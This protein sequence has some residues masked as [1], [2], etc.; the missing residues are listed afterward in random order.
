MKKSTSSHQNAEDTPSNA[1]Q[2]AAPDAIA[3]TGNS[4][5]VVPQ[6][7]AL[8]TDRTFF[9]REEVEYPKLFIATSKS[10]RA[11]EH[12]EG[13]LVTGTGD[14]LAE[15]GE[16]RRIIPG[17]IKFWHQTVVPKDETPMVWNNEA[18]IDWGIYHRNY[19][20]MNDGKYVVTLGRVGLY[21]EAK[22]DETC[23]L[24]LLHAPDGTGYF[25]MVTA[26][27]KQHMWKYGGKVMHSTAE[28]ENKPYE[29]R[30]WNLKVV[31]RKSSAGNEYVSPSVQFAGFTSEATQNWIGS[32]S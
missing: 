32:L 18:E 26:W 27:G 22:E 3:T 31:D 11:K 30:T 17:M 23:A 10:D 14:V 21:M 1:G 7:E 20:N 12:G 8:I 28:L 5:I 6:N 29:S 13:S 9:N 25:P 15:K 24:P 4:G 19:H 16:S 2:H